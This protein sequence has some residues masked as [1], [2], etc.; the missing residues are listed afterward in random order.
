MLADCELDDL[1][2]ALDHDVA[3]VSDSF[4]G[5]RWSRHQH[6]DIAQ[7]ANDDTATTSGERDLMAHSALRLIWHE[8]VAILHEFNPDHQTLLPNLGNLSVCGEGL[9]HLLN[10]G[11]TVSDIIEHLALFQQLQ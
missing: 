1:G 7:R 2:N 3:Q 6:D 5:H 9:K 4:D 8:A 10:R 11:C